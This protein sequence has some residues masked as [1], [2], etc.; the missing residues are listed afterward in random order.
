LP[1]VST[2]RAIQTLAARGA[3]GIAVR[4]FDGD[5]RDDLAV[6]AAAGVLVFTNSADDH[7]R[8]FSAKPLLV[9]EAG[10][11]AAI[12]AGDLDSDGSIALVVAR[13][14]AASLVLFGT[15]PDGF[16]TVTLDGPEGA[17]AV[18]LGD[19]DGDSLVD[20]ALAHDDATIVSRNL[21]ARLFA[22]PETAAA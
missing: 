14:G 10:G 20:V 1:D 6:A 7:G 9:D 16:E 13:P 19:V 18:A 5:G 8:P 22:A 4:D 11:G 15:A 12:A 3:R 21:G 17:V 2:V